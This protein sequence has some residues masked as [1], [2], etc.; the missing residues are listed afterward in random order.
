MSYKDVL[1]RTF[2]DIFNEILTFVRELHPDNPHI[3]AG[4]T[5]FRRAISLNYTLLIS[6]WYKWVYTPYKDNMET[7]GLDFFFAKEYHHDLDG[8]SNAG[9]ILNTIEQL[10]D[11]LREMAPEHKTIIQTKLT[12]LNKLSAKWVQCTGRS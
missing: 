6:Q 10:R 9:V 2:N 4:H 3:I 7:D 8:M 12:H 5:S 11:P 1:V